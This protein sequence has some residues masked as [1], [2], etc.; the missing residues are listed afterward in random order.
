MK[1][2]TCCFLAVTAATV[3]AQEDA[4]DYLPEEIPA[5]VYEAPVI[6]QAPVLYQAPVV[7]YAPV[8]YLMPL[9]VPQ[10]YAA[11]PCPAPSTVFYIGG[12]GSS[13]SYAHCGTTGSTLMHL[14]RQQACA[15]G[16]QFNLPR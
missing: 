4:G 13:Y 16:Y 9:T 15:S 14:G 12:R 3:C 8:Y 2:F 1:T 5:V 11:G 6:Y 7:Y 10:E